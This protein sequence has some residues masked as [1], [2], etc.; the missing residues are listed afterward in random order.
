L[1]INVEN[2]Y[3]SLLLNGFYSFKTDKMK[4]RRDDVKAK[5]YVIGM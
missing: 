3:L 2:A 5:I 4:V 1:Y